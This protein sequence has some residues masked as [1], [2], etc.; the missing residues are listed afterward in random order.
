MMATRLRLLFTNN[1]KKNL[2]VIYSDREKCLVKRM[3]L[4]LGHLDGLMRNW[5]N[6]VALENIKCHQLITDHLRQ[7]DAER[8]VRI[9]VARMRQASVEYKNSSKDLFV[10]IVNGTTHKLLED[11]AD[12]ATVND[13]TAGQVSRVCQQAFTAAEI[14]E[15]LSELVLESAECLEGHN[16]SRRSFREK[17][18]CILR[19]EE[20]AFTSASHTNMDRRNKCS[21]PRHTAPIFVRRNTDTQDD[22]NGAPLR[23]ASFI[24]TKTCESS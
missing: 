8:Q 15:Q 22:F 14:Y 20:T 6:W 4:G 9:A 24:K 5:V 12:D 21:V 23:L 16:Q 7:K 10:H 2:Y 13:F 11:Q 3:Q 19:Y 1:F 18:D 17:R